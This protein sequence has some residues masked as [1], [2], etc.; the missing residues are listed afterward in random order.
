[1]KTTG[2]ADDGKTPM[3]LFNLNTSSHPG[4]ISIDTSPSVM[5]LYGCKIYEDETLVRDFVPAQKGN[6][7]GLY[8][9]VTGSFSGSVTET[10]FESTEKYYNINVEYNV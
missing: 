1:M 7:M 10:P 9:K 6:M 5:T 8:D 2:T 3:L 4:G